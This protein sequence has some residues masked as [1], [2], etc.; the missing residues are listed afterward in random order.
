MQFTGAVEKVEA[1]EQWCE[2]LLKVQKN[3]VWHTQIGS[4]LQ[5]EKNNQAAEDRARRALEIDPNDW[6]ASTLLASLL[7]PRE[8]ITILKPAAEALESSGQWKLSSPHRM[9]LAK[10]LCILAELSWRE[11]HIDA[12]IGFWNR[13]V[14]VD[15]TDYIREIWC[16]RYLASQERWSEIMKFLGKIQEES[17]E[18]LQGL[19]ELLA[20]GSGRLFP[21]PIALRAAFHT[22]QL[23]FLVSAYERAVELIEERG[24]R[25]TACKLLYHCGQA[26]HALGNRSSTAI[27]HWRRALSSSAG[28]VD[29][30]LLSSLVSV[31]A[32]YYARKADASGADTEAVSDY[33]KKIETLL[34]E[35]TPESDVIV[36]PRLY[37]ARYY[38]RKGNQVKAKQIA[39]DSV[40]LSLDILS[41]DDEGNDLPAYS[42]LLSVFIAFGDMAN[43]TATRALLVLNFKRKQRSIATGS[44]VASG[45]TRNR[46]SGVGIALTRPLR[47]SVLRRSNRMRSRLQ[48]VTVRINFCA[49]LGWTI[50]WNEPHAGW[51]RLKARRSHLRIGWVS[52]RRSMSVSRMGLFDIP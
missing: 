4:I 8:G 24:E 29:K 11:G 1:I 5:L 50:P 48:C 7:N 26:T 42:Q 3:S 25:N 13:A 35:G 36:P 15:F 16:V 34:P 47:T 9:G 23:E 37:I 6:R 31:I 10:M 14:E 17:T 21:H 22:E 19:S 28:N 12:A 2:G 41:D 49:P 40:Q 45:H 44:A 38:W 46:R 32:P 33:L 51:C 43:L 39:R 52:S 27:K 20:W 18:Q 30:Y